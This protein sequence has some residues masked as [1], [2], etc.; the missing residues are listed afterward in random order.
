M[1]IF[2]YFVK[3]SSI[4]DIYDK[5]VIDTLPQTSSFEKDFKSCVD[6]RVYFSVQEIL[7][8]GGMLYQSQG[9]TVVDFPVGAGDYCKKT[10]FFPSKVCY[11]P[12]IENF[13][14]YGISN[15]L[16]APLNIPFNFK[17]AGPFQGFNTYSGVSPTGI[18]NQQEV[19]P[20][21]GTVVLPKLCNKD[22]LNAF[23]L[24]ARSFSCSPLVY[25]DGDLDKNITV[26]SQLNQVL[27]KTIQNCVEDLELK[28]TTDFTIS[29][30][31][32]TTFLLG[33]DSTNVYFNLTISYTDGPKKVTFTPQYE[34]PLRIKKLYTLGYAI[35]NE[36]IRN[37][38]F[39]K[40]A[41][42]V[43][44]TDYWDNKF[45]VYVVKNYASEFSTSDRYDDLV[46][47]EDRSSDVQYTSSYDSLF[48]QLNISPYTLKLIYAV[49]NRRPYL[50]YIPD[51]PLDPTITGYDYAEVEGIGISK[52]ASDRTVQFQVKVLDP[53]EG[54]SEEITFGT[55]GQKTVGVYGSPQ[56]F[57]YDTAVTLSWA[58]FTGNFPAIS[59]PN[60]LGP[61]TIP[62]ELKCS[63]MCKKDNFE[64]KPYSP[65]KYQLKA[66]ISDGQYSDFQIFNVTVNP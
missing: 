50:E 5:Q 22:G 31:G 18:F 23:D 27:S 48:N 26:Q 15:D 8:Q 66:D 24:H 42:Y 9:G 21:F 64:T 29:G 40:D 58:Y 60:T 61:I 12:S 63:T 62:I 11:D 32:A 65:S 17:S 52:S 35:A 57:K 47:I 44:L 33:D 54:D 56:Y 46:I 34:Y 59:V 38:F 20:W 43:N 45:A 19:A 51:L 16:A 14:N 30:D 36:D 41:D 7:L 4:S 37:I 49:E 1:L 10:S 2:I 55:L 39:N 13:I 6:Q 28:D 25:N 53:D 3:S